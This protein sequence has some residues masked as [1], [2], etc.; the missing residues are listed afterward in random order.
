[1]RLPP[2]YEAV[3][4]T[5]KEPKQQPKTQKDFYRD[6]NLQSPSPYSTT[7]ELKFTAIYLYRLEFDQLMH[8]GYK[9]W[10][11]CQPNTTKLSN[12]LDK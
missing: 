6:E 4:N 10:K 12:Q 11:K 2:R 3:K 1:M 9:N 7:E 8:F 5:T